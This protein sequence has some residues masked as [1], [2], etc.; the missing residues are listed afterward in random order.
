MKIA[1]NQSFRYLKTAWN[2]FNHQ[3]VNTMAKKIDWTNQ[4]FNFLGVI[5]GVLLAF[6]INERANSNKDR[7]ESLII[8]ESL[9]G[10]LQEDIQAYENFLIPQNKLILQNL[11]NLLEL[12]N[13]GDYEN[14]DEPFSMALQVENYGPTSATYTSTKSTGKLALFEDIELQKQLSNY[15]ESI[16]EESVK[17]GE[18]QVQYFTSELL[19]WLSNNMDLISNQLYR[20][21]DSGILLNK[22]LVYSS[23]I[24]QKIVSYEISLEKAKILKEELEKVLEENK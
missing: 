23:L 8:M 5:L 9:L 1:S 19:A 2:S 22:L 18:Y 21:S 3:P 12:I 14:I 11:E 17:K 16:A 15:Y 24:D 10:D 20:P 7:K 4:F 13:D 6:F